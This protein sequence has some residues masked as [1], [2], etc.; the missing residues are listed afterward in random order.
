MKLSYPEVNSALKD[1]LANQA[2]RHLRAIAFGALG[3]IVAW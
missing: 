2:G 3:T 1:K